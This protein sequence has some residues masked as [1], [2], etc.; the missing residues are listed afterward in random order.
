MRT[1]SKNQKIRKMDC[2]EIFVPLARE[3]TVECV[4]I[5]VLRSV[6]VTVSVSVSVHLTVQAIRTYTINWKGE[7]YIKPMAIYVCLEITRVPKKLIRYCPK[8]LIRFMV[9]RS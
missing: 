3:V 9:F 1:K 7:N 8:K 4:C 6:S 5:F 2:H